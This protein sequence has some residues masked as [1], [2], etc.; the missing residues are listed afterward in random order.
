MKMAFQFVGRSE[1]KWSGPRDKRYTIDEFVTH[2]SHLMSLIVASTKIRLTFLPLSLRDEAF[3][4]YYSII[5]NSKEFKHIQ[6]SSAIIRIISE[7]FQTPE[8]KMLLRNQLTVLKLSEVRSEGDTD[9][10][11]FE[12]LQRPATRIQKTLGM[13]Y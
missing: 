1:N 4:E 12:N 10:L 5:K 2:Y 8:F 13:E 7:K 11:A 6:N 3:D 9:Q